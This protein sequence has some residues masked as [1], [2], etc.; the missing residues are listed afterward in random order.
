MFRLKKKLGN[1]NETKQ[2]KEETG[3]P[4]KAQSQKFRQVEHVRR[5]FIKG[6]H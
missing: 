1:I 6:L 4:E 3:Y 2:E 5:V